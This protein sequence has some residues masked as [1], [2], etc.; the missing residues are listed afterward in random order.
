LVCAPP[1]YGQSCN[2]ISGIAGAYPTLSSDAKNIVA[3]PAGRPKRALRT[4]GRRTPGDLWPWLVVPAAL[5]VVA[6]GA[7]PIVYTALLS[8]LDVSGGFPVLLAD[9]R[10]IE[11]VRRTLTLAAI[12][13]PIELLLGLALACVFLGRMPGKSVFV[14]LLAVPALA[15]PTIGG[16]AWRILFDNDLGPFNQILGWITGAAVV[17]QWTKDPDF[18]PAAILIADIWQWTP[19]MF[20][21]LYAALSNVDRDHLVAAEIDDAGPWRTLFIVVLPAIWPA[22]GIAIL[23]RAL[24]LLRLFDVVLALTRGGPEA[25]TLSLFAYE[26]LGQASGSGGVAALAFAVLLMVSLP[27]TLLFSSSSAGRAR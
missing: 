6:V 1:E 26:R 10:F 18:I 19:F 3:D 17:V 2:P 13:L 16:S 21:L 8:L 11:A 20:V 4:S 14:T 24:D 9:P 15:A 27:L 5:T 12:A 23:V 22:V 7:F 25:E